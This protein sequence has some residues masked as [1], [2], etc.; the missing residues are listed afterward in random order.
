MEKE[1]NTIK[2]EHL[3][4]QYYI[5]KMKYRLSY[6][7]Y[8]KSLEKTRQEH[9]IMMKNHQD[10]MDFINTNGKYDYLCPPSDNGFNI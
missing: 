8:L 4:H 7:R 5:L 1:L 9:E 6:G 10:L 3:A 2:Q